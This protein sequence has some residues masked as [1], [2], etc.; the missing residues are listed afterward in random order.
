MAFS[1]VLIFTPISS[2]TIAE[3]T[4]QSSD[5]S[6]NIPVAPMRG[7][8]KIGGITKDVSSTTSPISGSEAKVVVVEVDVVVSIEVS[9]ESSAPPHAEAISDK[10]IT[11]VF[12]FFNFILL[13]KL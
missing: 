12:N 7:F 8:N 2:G 11:V 3:T 10:T 1:P 9:S 13:N 6:V 5:V 4:S